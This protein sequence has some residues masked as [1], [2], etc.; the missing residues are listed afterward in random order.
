MTILDQDHP[1]P[2]YF[3]LG[4]I[5][6]KKIF[7]GEWPPDAQIPTEEELTA[8]YEVSRGTVRKALGLLEAEGLIRRHQGR[9]T[10][11]ES[12][13]FSSLM[14]FA[15]HDTG[16]E[17]MPQNGPILSETVAL[18]E[19][20]A[21]EKVAAKLEIEPGTKVLHII[22][23]KSQGGVVM[24]YEERFLDRRLSPGL[25]DE[26]IESQ[27]VHWLLSQKYAIP[28]VRVEYSIEARNLSGAEAER[29]QAES[30]QP[31]FFVDRLT[32]LDHDRPAVWY[33]AIYRGDYYRFST[34][35]RSSL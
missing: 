5:L 18:E 6:R 34:E 13:N 24:I 2:K 8:E 35:F 32:Y 19:I 14:T 12:S 16:Q 17:T 25:M 30:G 10:Y 15:L 21:P 22:Q 31:A 7:D 11:V 23:R 29:L 26:D 3:Q 33:R 20:P 28:L 9:G 4:A 27:N 1:I